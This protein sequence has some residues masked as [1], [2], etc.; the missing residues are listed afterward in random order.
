MM[1]HQLWC[2]YVEIKIST[3]T[4]SFLKVLHKQ[5]LSLLVLLLLF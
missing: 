1:A 2:I 5:M 3:L 4:I